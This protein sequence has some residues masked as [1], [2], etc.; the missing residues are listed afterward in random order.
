MGRPFFL[1]WVFHLTETPAGFSQIHSL[2]VSLLQVQLSSQ[3]DEAVL[4]CGAVT[5]RLL[6]SAINKSVEAALRLNWD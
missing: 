3:T 2:E 1:F 6:L 5:V 4:F